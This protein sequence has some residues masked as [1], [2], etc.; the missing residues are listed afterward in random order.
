MPKKMLISAQHA[1]QVRVAVVRDRALEDYHV[2]VAEAGLSRGNIY[3]GVVAN[4]HP[5][6]NAA[7]VD[8]GEEK[9]G[10]LPVS[11]VH[12]HAYQKKPP[13]DEKRPRIDQVLDRG[14]PILVQVTKDGVGQKGPALTTNVSLAGRYLV[15]TPFDSVRGISRK[16]A[17][18]G[19]RKKAKQR[20]AKLNLPDG[21]GVILRTN[22]LDQNQ[23]TLARDLSALLRLWKKI[24]AESSKGRGHRLLYSDQDLLIQ[25][26]RDLLDSEIDVIIVDDADAHET[27]Q[28]YMRAFMPRTKIELKFH[29]ER[30]PLFTKHRLEMQIDRIYERSAPLP[31]GGSIVID[32]TEALSAIDVNSGRATHT[33]DHDESILKVNLEAAEEVGRQLRLRDIGGLVVVDFIDMR[34]KKHQRKVEKA[35][36]DAMKGDR[37]RFSVGRLSSNGLLEINRQRI[38]Q[39]LRLRTHRPCAHCQGLGL[40]PSPEFAAVHLKGRIESRAAT[41]LVEG[42]LVAVHPEVADALQNRFRRD[43]VEMETTFQMDIEIVS[44]AAM[45]PGEERLEWRE[46]DERPDSVSTALRA[47]DLTP[48]RPAAVSA[49]DL[50]TDFDDDEEIGDD[51]EEKPTRSRRRRRRRRR[52]GGGGD[53]ESGETPEERETS[54]E[55]DTE[56]DDESE[57]GDD[58]REDDA[59]RGRRRS[60][61]RRSRRDDEGD[62][63]EDST[64]SDEDADDAGDEPAGNADAASEENGD[65]EEE[66]RPKRRRRRRRRRRSSDSDGEENRDESDPDRSDSEDDEDDSDE[67]PA[68]TREPRVRRD[69]A[70]LAA[71]AAALDEPWR[72]WGTGV[73]ED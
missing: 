70:A 14:K 29:D 27:V 61:R 15:L 42:V 9:H 1:G 55:T 31:S 54:D 10:F 34:L 73:D 18:D 56:A 58:D 57:D 51:D 44:S 65:Q 4:I 7:F 20:L 66:A 37:A 71:A 8:L 52:R 24:Q 67:R 72:W 28:T 53:G 26:L 46:R 69:A 59:P 5:S 11:D 48:R 62:R 47:G 19:M 30:I 33:Q 13:K 39:A 64:R 23:A 40:L 6:L 32:P 38:R 45:R 63:S 16:V 25:A 68:R 17:D 2:E 41:G 21:H 49:A 36:R 43:L 22:G 12:E 60:R 50:E 3:R 35:M